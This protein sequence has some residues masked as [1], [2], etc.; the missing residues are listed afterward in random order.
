MAK[1]W[2]GPGQEKTQAFTSHPAGFTP[3]RHFLLMMLMS[4]SPTDSG[5]PSSTQMV[6]DTQEMRDLS[7]PAVAIKSGF[8][9]SASWFQY[10]LLKFLI[11]LFFS[12]ALIL[13]QNGIAVQLSLIIRSLVASQSHPYGRQFLNDTTNYDKG[14]PLVF[15]D[16]SAHNWIQRKGLLPTGPCR[17]PDLSFAPPGPRLPALWLGCSQGS[18]AMATTQ[19]PSWPP[20]LLPPNHCT[21]AI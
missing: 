2:S 19:V 13:I 21:R 18:L 7:Q 16:H 14:R 6:Q 4:Q 20:F 8:S 1:G 3:P 15:G 17:Y 5:Q 9:Q 10:L 11:K 12:P